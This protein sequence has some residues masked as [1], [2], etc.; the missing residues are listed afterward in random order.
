MATQGLRAD[1]GGSAQAVLAAQ[2]F[3]VWQVLP[4]AAP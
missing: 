3:G 2:S 1:A 4:A